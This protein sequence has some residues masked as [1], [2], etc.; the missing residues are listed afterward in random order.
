MSA[1]NL[2]LQQTLESSGQKA[3][4]LEQE[5]RDLEAENQALQR[6]LEALRLA[7]KQLERSE[8][9]RKALEQEVAQL[10]K[11][12]KL[13]EKETKRLWQQV[14]LKDAV[15]DDSTAKLSAAEKESRALDKELAR[16][17]DA[18]SKL[19]ELERDNRDL[20]KQVTVHTRT[21]TTL[22]EVSCCRGVGRR[23]QGRV[24]GRGWRLG[25]RAQGHAVGC[26]SQTEVGLCVLSLVLP[27]MVSAEMRMKG[28]VTCYSLPGQS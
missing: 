4:A 18:A 10:E 5:L 23:S 11:D 19:K 27:G 25:P 26:A 15:L 7:N 24:R 16:C 6:D 20:T 14:E 28:D 12:K 22:R 8:K 2:R 21:L 3:Q 1:E 17:R 9:D 13:L